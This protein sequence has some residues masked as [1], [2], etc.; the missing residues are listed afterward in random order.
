MQAKDIKKAQMEEGAKVK[1]IKRTVLGQEVWLHR[2]SCTE[3]EIYEDYIAEHP[4]MK[5]AKLFQMCMRDDH[6]TVIW[7][8][9]EVTIL[10]GKCFDNDVALDLCGLNGFG[11]RAGIDIL[12]NSTAT[13]GEGGSSGQPG[14]TTAASQNFAN[15]TTITSSGSSTNAS[16]TG[17][18]ETRQTPN[19]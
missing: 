13:P 8:D 10:G 9:N 11:P 6:G 14:S 19:D 5:I 18:Q 3:S 2:L 7:H 17:P 4:H 12:K 16:D 1:R 15:V